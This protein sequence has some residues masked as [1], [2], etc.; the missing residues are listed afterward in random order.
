[1]PWSRSRMPELVGRAAARPPAAPAAAPSRSTRRRHVGDRA[2]DGVVLAARPGPRRPSRRS[3]CAAPRTLAAHARCP[4]RPGRKS[5]PSG[6]SRTSSLRPGPPSAWRSPLERERA[7]RDPRGRD[8]PELDPAERGVEPRRRPRSAPCSQIQRSACCAPQLWPIMPR[9]PS[10]RT[11]RPSDAQRPAEAGRRQRAEQLRARQRRAVHP[12]AR[13]VEQR[14]A[15]RLEAQVPL[16]AVDRP[17]IAAA[18]RRMPDASPTLIHSPPPRARLGHR[19]LVRAAGP[20]AVRRT[21]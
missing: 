9:Q 16:R 12:G 19:L 2:V 3:P 4:C 17:P 20:R 1:M 14:R 11:L 5:Q 6:A 7:V 13:Q 10:T 21:A 18:V 8:R 15:R